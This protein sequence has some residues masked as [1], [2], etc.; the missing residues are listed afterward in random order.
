MARLGDVCTFY[1]GT[2]FPNIYQGHTVGE[3]PFYKVGDISRNILL[4]N[5]ELQFCENYIDTEILQK[6]KGKVLPE[7]TIVFA[8]IGEALRLNKRAVTTCK[9]LVDNN[10]MGIQPDKDKLDWRYFYHFMCSVDLQDG[11]LNL[12]IF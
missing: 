9:C 2:G 3:Y 6:I 5:R 11:L 8:K 1:S 7:K 12:P 4:G 10:V